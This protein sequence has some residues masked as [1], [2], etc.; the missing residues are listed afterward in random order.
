VRLVWA[1]VVDVAEERPGL[2]RLVVSLSDGTA[3][4]AI[5]YPDLSGGCVV[6]ESVLLNTTAVD[7][8][9]GTGGTHFV[10]ARGPGPSAGTA[11]DRPSGGHIMKLRYTPL[12]KDVVCVEAQEGP[13]HGIMAKAADAEA[14]PVVCCGLHSQVPLAAAAVKEIAPDACIAYVMTDQAALPLALSELVGSCMDCGLLDVTVTCGQAFGGDVEAVTLHSGLL[15]ARHVAK[16][17]VAIV[18]LG[19]GIVGTGTVFGHGGV[20]QGEAVNAAAA[21]GAS[22]VAALRLS[23]ADDRERHRGVSHHCLTALGRV[24]LAPARVAVPALEP[25]QAAILE[26]ALADAGV[27]RLHDRADVEARPLPDTRGVRVRTMGRGP[28][29]DPAF[30]AAAAAAGTV[31]GRMLIA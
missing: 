31:A 30:F 28:D 11:L 26:G 1:S 4:V 18:A 14:M 22:P 24:A 15:A 23:F 25:Q 7:L 19:P 2:Q 3:G 10:V 6:G 8:S 20:S 29:Q 27:W 5:C 16:V 9:L 12:Q 17:D 21:V 13:T